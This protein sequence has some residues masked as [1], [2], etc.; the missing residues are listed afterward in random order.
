MRGSSLLEGP[1]PHSQEEGKRQ[2]KHSHNTWAA[3]PFS[4]L[5]FSPPSLAVQADI[6]ISLDSGVPWSLQPS[7]GLLEKHQPP[8]DP[9]NHT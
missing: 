8:L 7:L 4:A 2:R 3:K 9:T 5:G 6:I 1:L